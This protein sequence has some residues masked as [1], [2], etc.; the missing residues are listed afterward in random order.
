MIYFFVLQCFCLLGFFNTVTF[1]KPVFKPSFEVE[2][3]K[4]HA[5]RVL[6]VEGIA[7]HFCGAA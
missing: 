3:R 5:F 2:G 1:V 4:E 6:G 7:S